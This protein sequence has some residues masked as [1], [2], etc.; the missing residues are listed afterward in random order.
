MSNLIKTRSIDIQR[1]LNLATGLIFSIFVV[2]TIRYQ[3]KLLTYIEMG[4]ESE[5]IVAAKMI[6]AG[7]S[8]YSGIF[9]HHGPLTFLPGVLLEYFGDFGVPGYRIPIA[10]LQL[11]ATRQGK[12]CLL[13]EA[14]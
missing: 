13:L 10:I 12:L 6:A 4:D 2:L 3:T 7:D 11:V 5:T 14:V 8:L 1:I 9:N